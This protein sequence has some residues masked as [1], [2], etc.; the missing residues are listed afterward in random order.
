MQVTSELVEKF[1]SESKVIGIIGLD[2]YGLHLAV[3]LALAGIRVIGFDSCDTTVNQLNYGHNSGLDIET[4]MLHLEEHNVG[5]CATT[6]FSRIVEC[7]ALLVCVPE[8]FKQ[9]CE[10]NV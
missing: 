6:D 2:N 3:N 10:Q 9:H 7:D 1:V 5:L 8:T 4:R